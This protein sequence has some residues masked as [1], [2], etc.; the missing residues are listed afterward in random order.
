MKKKS[1]VI[2]IL[3]VAAI[4]IL[5]IFY[6]ISQSPQSPP[7]LTVEEELEQSFGNFWEEHYTK[8]A[9]GYDVSNAEELLKK[10]RRTWDEG[11][12]ARAE[13]ILNEAFSSLEKSELPPNATA[14]PA[15]SKR[16][17][18]QEGPIY[19]THP[20][21]YGENGTFR[22][23]TDHLP[24]IAEM[25]VKTVEILPIW[26]H[27][28]IPPTGPRRYGRAFSVSDY[29]EICSDYGTKEELKELIEEVHKYDMRVI[30]DFM[31]CA[32][33]DGS[34]EYRNDWLI[35]VPLSELK[36]SGLPLEYNTYEGER[37]VYSGC[38]VVDQISATCEIYGK[39]V[40]KEVILAHYPYMF[41]WAVD[42]SNPE[43]IDYFT[44]VAEYYTEEYE[45]DG[46]RLDSPANNWNPRVV[47]GDHSAIELFNR[48]K[49]EI[50]SVNPNAVV[51]SEAPV[52]IYELHMCG[53]PYNSSGIWDRISEAS[54]SY[55]FL[56]YLF[57]S[58]NSVVSGKM[59]SEDL[60]NILANEQIWYGRTRIRFI[61]TVDSRVHK[62]A[63]IQHRALLVLASTVPGVPL[64]QAGEE[65]GARNAFVENA[66][67]DWENGDYELREFYKK[68]FQ[69]RSENEALKYG[70]ISN[71][72]KSEGDTIAYLRSYGNDKVIV[73][74]NFRDK[75]ATSILDL[76]F[77]SDVT[78][79]DALNEESF[80]VHDPANFKIILPAYG[81]RVLVLQD[82]K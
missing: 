56:Y 52:A 27:P 60:T 7:T 5:A 1:L 65:V 9:S 8:K 20:L 43:A 76:P 63:P 3:A 18:L 17:W 75:A 71:V 44:K 54:W 11:D 24:A 62:V 48:A 69:I 25:G 80:V 32:T 77:E 68:V 40:D 2:G 42:R 35:K 13:S 12:C 57:I 16:T 26:A 81:S 39:I 73:V 34:V 55:Y 6:S 49:D 28:S 4:F 72:W 67:V 38:K 29:Y 41:G 82:R 23:I 70:D 53:T 30:L 66:P 19:L 58:E 10:A 74:L 50:K 33:F 37:Y 64:I 61:D 36:N 21:Y 14:L 31:T 59:G 51:I 79:Y 45:I 15:Y 22:D 46:W 47:K 78:L